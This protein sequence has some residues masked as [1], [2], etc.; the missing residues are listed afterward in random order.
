MEVHEKPLRTKGLGDGPQKVAALRDGHE[1]LLGFSFHHLAE[2]KYQP[3]V[4]AGQLT[5]SR[6]V[7]TR[8]RKNKHDRW[9]ER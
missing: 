5:R 3:V 1:S 6:N 9:E 4:L 2:Q 7:Q 8:Q